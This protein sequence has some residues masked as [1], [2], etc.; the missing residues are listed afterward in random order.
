LLAMTSSM[1]P[2]KHPEL[3]VCLCLRWSARVRILP[4]TVGAEGIVMVS[5][6]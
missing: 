6:L 3:V 5:V 2:Q 1:F 4:T